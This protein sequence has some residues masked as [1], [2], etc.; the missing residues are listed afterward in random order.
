[1][2]L[3]KATAGLVC[4]RHA[5][6]QLFGR[7]VAINSKAQGARRA[8][9]RKPAS[10]LLL[11]AAL[12]LF[13]LPL[14]AGRATAADAGSNCAVGDTSTGN[15]L[16]ATNTV[17]GSGNGDAT[18]LAFVRQQTGDPNAVQIACSFTPQNAKSGSWTSTSGQTVTHILVKAST[19]QQLF[20]VSPPST[21]GSW[22]TACIVNNGGKQPDI[23]GVF[24]YS[25]EPAAPG[26]GTIT[27]LKE[28]E[29]GFGT[30]S[31]KILGQQSSDFSLTTSVENNPVS[32]GAMVRAA[33]DYTIEESLTDEWKLADIS[34]TSNK[35]TTFKESGKKVSFT[36]G[37]GENAVCTFKNERKGDKG[38]VI[39]KKKAIGGS[40]T[41]NFGGSLGAFSIDAGEGATGTFGP[42]RAA[43]GTYNI[44]EIVP[45]GW[46]LASAVCRNTLGQTVGSA[47][48]AE[49]SFE[50]TK[51][52]TVT[53]TFENHKDSGLT[54]VKE[55]VGNGPGQT[56]SFTGSGPDGAVAF[57]LQ[58]GQ[59][60]PVFTKAGS[61]TIK[62]A[63]HAGWTLAK[64][65][66]TGD[67]GGGDSAANGEVKIKLD[68]GENITCTFTNE[69]QLAKL[70]IKKVTIGG[71]G[72][73]DFKV[74]GQLHGEFTGLGN[75]DHGSLELPLGEY[76]IQEVNL[77]AGWTLKGASC[78]EV[79]SNNAVKVN[80]GQNGVT[81]V[82]TNFKE[83]DDKME[84]VTKVFIHRRVDNLLSHDP[85][86]ARLLRRLDGQ[87]EESLKDAGSY[88]P[89]KLDGTAD[90][91]TKDVQFTASLSGM[92]AAAAASAEKKAK[93]AGLQFS[94]AYYPNS[95]L[96]TR[97]DLWVEGHLTSYSDSTGG[98]DRDGDFKILYVGADYAIS[99]D[100]LI[101]ALLQ[102]DRTDEKL[103]DPSIKGEIA[104]TGWMAGPYVGVRLRE[105]L[106]FDARAAWGRSS[107][108][109]ALD[110]EDAGY[111]TGK[112]ETDRW[113]ARATLTGN[114]HFGALR[115]SPEIGIAYGN[116]TSE[117]YLNSIGQ[118]VGAADITIGRMT[119]G[120]EFG[121]RHIAD[122]G[123][124][125]EPQLS[126]K[127]IWNFDDDD[128]VLSTGAVKPDEL[129]AAVEAGLMVKLPDGKAL[130]ASGSYDGI[131]D[132]DFEAW[133]GKLW[134]NI[135]LD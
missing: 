120:P 128:L 20:G 108:D 86:R 131:G 72:S 87:Q 117:D 6:G 129:R 70:K 7:L 57:G 76:T 78:G 50:L 134:L 114:Y 132:D 71:N 98:I 130:R 65:S 30:F 47:D 45:D 39:V 29:G 116:E 49:V 82:F 119:F 52:D 112:F 33:G 42:I 9:C 17:Q 48:A 23:S 81:C 68:P 122:D 110:D 16:L 107:N 11:I 100:V 36:L 32:S 95:V 28:T 51:N 88:E 109:I 97:F 123:T 19:V 83:N 102:W 3:R 55:V 10:S 12:A 94:S 101:G 121:Y 44:S 5:A 38:E 106:F 62:E 77:P 80:L 24:C 35:S 8:G 93:E 18:R 91:S 126:I 46:D 4:A 115:L 54:I 13:L 26:N 22:S 1:M 59:Q 118:T 31:F 124:L 92:R 69:A 66:C 61:Y 99:P 40:D 133:S 103:D 73:F 41:F 43:V 79:D 67:F 63:A 96:T 84:D 89:L 34:C 74:N 37:E 111:R 53:C 21:S 25:T 60:S 14:A 15:T 56:F 85:D 113:L 127:G 2:L 75:G 58:G 27:V 90:G 64:L 105:D 125:V 135:P 104:G